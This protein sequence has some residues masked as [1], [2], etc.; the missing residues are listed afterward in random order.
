MIDILGKLC[1]EVDFIVNKHKEEEYLL[2]SA[3]NEISNFN[4]LNSNY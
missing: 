2:D 1:I 3:L 4:Y